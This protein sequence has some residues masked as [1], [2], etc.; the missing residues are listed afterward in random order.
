MRHFANF[1]VDY[2][3]NHAEETLR[4]LLE[5][6]PNSES[7]YASAILKNAYKPD[8]FKHAIDEGNSLGTNTPIDKVLKDVKDIGS[9]ASRVQVAH[10][11]PDSVMGADLRNYP[12]FPSLQD[13]KA[14]GEDKATY[15]QAL[16]PSLVFD[17]EFGKPTTYK[18]D[19]TPN[20]WSNPY[21]KLNEISDKYRMTNQ[22]KEF[23]NYKKEENGSWSLES[24]KKPDF[25]FRRA[26]LQESIS[27]SKDNIFHKPWLSVERQGEPIPKNNINISPSRL[28]ETVATANAVG[29]AHGGYTLKKAYD[30]RRKQ[31]QADDVQLTN[32][33]Q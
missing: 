13:Y 20:K 3:Q 11:H 23:L 6:H 22:D 4:G 17:N 12:K 21:S 9:L 33:Y 10:T 30:E 8:Y 15:G 18:Y 7:G 29:L 5:K 2:L 25:F 31:R 1:Y 16:N 32:K 28:G 19:Y 24:N 26:A 14:H 27:N